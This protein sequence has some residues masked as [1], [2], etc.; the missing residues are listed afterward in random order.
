M[1]QSNCKGQYARKDVAGASNGRMAVSVVAAVRPNQYLVFA[2]APSSAGAWANRE[3]FDT[4]VT[5]AVNK[6]HARINANKRVG[7]A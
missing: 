1:W 2:Y 7:H 4:L 5:R 3:E 6:L